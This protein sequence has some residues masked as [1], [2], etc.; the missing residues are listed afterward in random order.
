MNLYKNIMLF[1]DEIREL[2]PNDID[3]ITQSLLDCSRILRDLMIQINEMHDEGKITNE[4]YQEIFG[5]DLHEQH[6]H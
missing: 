3:K 6:Y 2:N 5:V 1:K 4:T